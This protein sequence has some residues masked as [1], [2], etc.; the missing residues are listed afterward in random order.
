GFRNSSASYTVSLLNPQ[1]ITDL[2]LVRHGLRV[3][4]R[5]YSNFLPLPDGNAFRLGGEAGATHLARTS[6]RDVERL[7]DYYAMLDRVVKVLRVLMTRTPP[8]VSDR[9]ALADWLNSYH[10]ARQLK[11]LD[12]RGRRDLLDLF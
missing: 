11:G 1:V 12:L 10:V 3:V 2:N 5:P 9:F 8:N 7:A 6:P 4:E